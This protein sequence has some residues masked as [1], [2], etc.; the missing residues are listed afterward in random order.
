MIDWKKK[1]GKRNTTHRKPKNTPW[2]NHCPGLF[3]SE[4]EA[5]H[6]YMREGKTERLIKSVHK[7]N[8]GQRVKQA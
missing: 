2:G 1:L 5:Y 8:R 4:N 7:D 3:K 6:D